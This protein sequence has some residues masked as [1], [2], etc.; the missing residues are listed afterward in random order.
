MK[1]WRELRAVVHGQ[2]VEPIRRLG[3][4]IDVRIRAAHE[5]EYRWRMPFGTKRS[6]VLACR[7]RSRLTNPLRTKMSPECLDHP[8]TGLRIVHIE[9]VAIQRRDLGFAGG[10]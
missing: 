3:L 10:A 5:P 8:P 1:D 9:R 4:R 2:F 6:K 7:R